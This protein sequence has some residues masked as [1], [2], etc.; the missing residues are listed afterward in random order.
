[1]VIR[2]NRIPPASMAGRPIRRV[3][4]FRRNQVLDRVKFEE[5]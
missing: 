5:R 3:D 2:H 1:M 4:S